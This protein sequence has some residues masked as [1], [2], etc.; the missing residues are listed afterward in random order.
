MTRTLRHGSDINVS[1]E[2]LIGRIHAM[3][4]V[5]TLLKGES[6]WQ[7]VKL[8]GSVRVAAIPHRTHAAGGMA[9]DIA[10]SARAAQSLSLLFFELA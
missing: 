6:E 3:S 10:V 4:N 7:G 2:L 9:P 1:G 5:V 8:K